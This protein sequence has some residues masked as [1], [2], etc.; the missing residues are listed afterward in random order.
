[1]GDSPSELSFENK[2]Q[3]SRRSKIKK[4]KNPHKA[5]SSNNEAIPLP[6]PSP[7]DDANKEPSGYGISAVII[8]KPS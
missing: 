4:L 8:H 5:P 2:S 1:M 7:V 3:R 6:S